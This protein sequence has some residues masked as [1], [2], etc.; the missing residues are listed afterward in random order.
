MNNKKML[1]IDDNINQGIDFRKIDKK[2][3]GIFSSKNLPPSK[4]QEMINNIKMFVLYDMGSEVKM[5]LG[6]K[7]ITSVSTNKGDVIDFKNSILNLNIKF[8]NKVKMSYVIDN[9]KQNPNKSLPTLELKIDSNGAISSISI[10]TTKSSLA[11]A[12]QYSPDANPN[13]WNFPFIVGDVIFNHNA[14]FIPRFEAWA[15]SIGI[16]VNGKKFI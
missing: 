12:S 15:K 13:N 6:S 8:P 5:K 7:N 2:V 1:I 10:D 16:F 9:K 11:Y 4:K 14:D 3:Q